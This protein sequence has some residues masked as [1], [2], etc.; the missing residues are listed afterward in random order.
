MSKEHSQPGECREWDKSQQQKK[1]KEQ[2]ALTPWRVQG[3]EQVMTPKVIERVSGTHI[4][5]S[6][7]R[8]TI[9]KAKESEQTRGAHQ[10]NS[11][12]GSISQDSK[13]K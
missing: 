4:L 10:L 11:T 7:D 2:V 8:R 1:V 6:R 3:E 12:E 5:S 13:R 9:R